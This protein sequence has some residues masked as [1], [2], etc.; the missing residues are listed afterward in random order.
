VPGIKIDFTKKRIIDFGLII[1][2]FKKKVN[3]PL[4]KKFSFTSG[5]MSRLQFPCISGL[6]L[7][8][9][10]PL[11]RYLI[12]PIFQTQYSIITTFH[13]SNCGAKRS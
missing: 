4:V 1:G 5:F 11:P 9:S 2:F 10:S 12:T 13:H 8:S 3:N 7:D 6:S